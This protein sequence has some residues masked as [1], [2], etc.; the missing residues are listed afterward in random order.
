MAL[1]AAI[2]LIFPESFLEPMWHLNPRAQESFSH[3]GGFAIL[4]LLPVSV[5]CLFAGI[6]LLC[7][8]RWAYWLGIAL[9]VVNLS[10][11]AINVVLGIEKRALVGIPIALTLILVLL[12]KRVRNLFH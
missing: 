12:S 9:L 4:L 10:G 2:S 8:R 5:A 11:D 3:L 6:G 1:I 7:L